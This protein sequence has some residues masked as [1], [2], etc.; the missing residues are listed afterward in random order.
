MTPLEEE[1]MED[2]KR[3]RQLLEELVLIFTEGEGSDKTEK[4]ENL[5]KLV[6]S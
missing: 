4:R 3:I 1:A 5:L 2:I 6:D